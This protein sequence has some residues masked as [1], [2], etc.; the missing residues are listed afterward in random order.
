MG[1]SFKKSETLEEN[2]RRVILRQGN[3]AL[4]HLEK[5]DGDLHH[6]V[7]QARKRFKQIRAILRLV[8]P[9]LGDKYTMENVAYRDMGRKLSD[10]RDA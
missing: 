3:K 2:L 8:R 4:S 10:L 9:A 7:H 5:E 1:F 6:G